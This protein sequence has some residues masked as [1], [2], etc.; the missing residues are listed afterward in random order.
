MIYTRIAYEEM[1]NFRKQEL[2]NKGDIMQGQTDRYIFLDN[3][4]T[5]THGKTGERISN[6]LLREKRQN[7]G[8]SKNK[9][10]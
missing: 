4:R 1:N 8:C 6:V 3:P 5:G 9:R 2:F 10:I 7:N